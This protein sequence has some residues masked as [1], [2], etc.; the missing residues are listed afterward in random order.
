[1]VSTATPCNNLESETAPEGG[2]CPQTPPGERRRGSGF[3]GKEES[4]AGPETSR[5]TAFGPVASSLWPY[6]HKSAQI[7]TKILSWTKFQLVPSEL[8]E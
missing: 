4:T 1:M 6:A 8:S 2:L 7:L 3:S 5:G